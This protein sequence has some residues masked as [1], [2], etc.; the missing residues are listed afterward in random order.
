MGIVVPFITLVIAWA[1]TL[2][3]VAAPGAAAEASTMEAATRW[4]LFIPGGFMFLASGVM[5]TVFAKSTA[6][7]IGW[8]TNGFQYEIGFVSLGLGAAGI[9]AANSS[10][11]AWLPIA[12][13]QSIF[14]VL[15]GANHV[16]EIV[17]ERNVA[18]GN[19]V[20][21]LYDFGLPVSYLIALVAVLPAS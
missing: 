6:K 1:L 4:L 5:H 11:P 3:D 18:P 12:V 8:Q 21:L 19:T 20:I 13:A 15:A 2:L 9:I 7:S 16:R 14:L 10:E 17:K